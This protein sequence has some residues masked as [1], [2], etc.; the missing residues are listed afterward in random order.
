MSLVADRLYDRVAPLFRENFERFGELGA[1][2]SI[3]QNGESVLDLHGGFRDSQRKEPWTADTIVLVWS[4]TKGIGSACMLHVL[5]ENKIDLGRRVADFWPEFAQNGK[6]EI[7]IAQLVSHSA[8]LCALDQPADILDYDSVV[9]AIAMQKPLWPPGSAHGYHAR[10]FGFLID[11]LVRRIAGISVS[12]YWRQTF[13]DPLSLDFWIGLPPGFNSRCANIYAA[14][15]GRPTEPAQFYRDLARAGTLQQRTFASPQGLQAVGAMN[16]PEIRA[17]SI[18]SFGGIGSA[19]AIAKFYALLANGGEMHGRRFFTDE[20][21]DRMITTLA[22]GTDR[23]FEI[24]TAFSAGLMKDPG[25]SERRIFGPSAR[26][27]G[28]PG[29]GGSHA[30]ADPEN[31]VAFAYVMNQMEQTLLPNEKSLRLVDAIYR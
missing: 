12:S 17:Q 10:T 2:V 30:F 7:T 16:K 29:A 18:V 27:F 15:S 1:A 25:N 9:R 8:G 3:W 14:K 24:P 31:N 20:T 23:I 13:G 28:H 6:G 4:T 19:S 5:Q 21:I 11:E 26:A 22:D